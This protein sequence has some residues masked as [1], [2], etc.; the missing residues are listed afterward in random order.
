MKLL[1][2]FAIFLLSIYS[3][4][5]MQAGFERDKYQGFWGNPTGLETN[6]FSKFTDISSQRE[7]WYKIS[8][9]VAEFWCA[10]SNIPFI[11]FGIRAYPENKK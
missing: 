3:Q 4:N 10:I 11:Y 5:I 1:R 8:P 6:F 9:Y 2:F 7:D